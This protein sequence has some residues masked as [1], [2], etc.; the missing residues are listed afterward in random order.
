MQNSEETSLASVAKIHHEIYQVLHQVLIYRG[1]AEDTIGRKL[2]EEEL[3]EALLKREYVFLSGARMGDSV[4]RPDVWWCIAL[5]AQSANSGKIAMF[6]EI[7]KA[8]Y[9]ERSKDGK[10][11]ALPGRL[12]II[13]PYEVQS[14]AAQ[15]NTRSKLREGR[16]IELEYMKLIPPGATPIRVRLLQA[17]HFRFDITKH[18]L[19]PRHSIVPAKEAAVLLEKCGLIA[20]NLPVILMRDPI[21]LYLDPEQGMLLRIE[22]SSAATGVTISYRVCLRR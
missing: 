19:V 12:D 11:I 16:G 15:G 14:R 13:Q 9:R 18:S 5:I 10:L 1:V 22:Q 3:N 17:D 7:V 6:R 20:A 4:G 8:A 21:V 2:S